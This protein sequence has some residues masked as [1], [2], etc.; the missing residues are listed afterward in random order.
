MLASAEHQKAVSLQGKVGSISVSFE[1]AVQKTQK[2]L[3]RKD[4]NVWK[5]LVDTDVLSNYK[6]ILNE[7][8]QKG[9]LQLTEYEENLVSDL[10]ADGYHA[11]GQFYS[12]LVNDIKVDVPING[13]LNKLSVGQ[14]LGW[15][16]G[17]NVFN[18][19]SLN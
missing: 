9:R 2:M 7:W 1:S 11:C 17:L 12:A 15:R 16:K 13:E 6:F 4:Q 14:V 19:I 3:V 5:A 18:C 10:M 8:R